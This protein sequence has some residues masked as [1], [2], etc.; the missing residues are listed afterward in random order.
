M[1][2]EASISTEDASELVDVMKNLPLLTREY[3]MVVSSLLKTENE[4]PELI[5]RKSID[6]LLGE[7][8]TV[9]SIMANAREVAI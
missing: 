1:I 6:K 3:E 5:R 8:L 9:S 2:S 7:L 4:T